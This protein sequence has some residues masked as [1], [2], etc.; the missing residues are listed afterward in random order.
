M[1]RPVVIVKVDLD[2]VGI[3][4]PGRAAKDG[5]SDHEAGETVAEADVRTIDDLIDELGDVIATKALSR[6]PETVGLELGEGLEPLT[7][8]V[9]V[10]GGC[11]V[12]GV[13]VD[14][15]AVLVAESDADGSLDVEDVG[16]PVPAFRVGREAALVVGTEGTVFDHEADEATASGSSLEPE[17][18]L[19]RGVK[20][21]E[22]E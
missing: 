8:K 19:K 17:D 16:D 14:G 10:L 21:N 18:D 1:I 7:K 15:G 6:D 13:V 2:V 3:L 20:G 22:G 9:I 11:R 5:V 12:V 4:L